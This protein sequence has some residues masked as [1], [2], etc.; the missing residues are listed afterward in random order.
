MPRIYVACLAS[1]NNGTLHGQ[2]ID[3]TA[4]ADEMQ[5]SVSTMLRASP[6]PNVRVPKDD[7]AAERVEELDEE[8]RAY[9]GPRTSDSFAELLIEYLSLTVLSAEEFAIHD[10]DGEELEGLGEY[11]GLAAVAS[12]IEAAELAVDRLG[13][14]G[15]AIVAAFYD[16]HSCRPDDARE[17]VDAVVEAYQGTYDSWTDW[18]EEYVDSTGMLEAMP[19]QLRYY[20]DYEAYGRDVR[21]NGDLFESKGFYFYNR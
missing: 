11:C 5:A 17:A 2:W 13:S 16:Y 7:E 4:D 9:L 20:F 19:E 21:L 3:A 15:V 18:A 10:F 8:I 6:Y 1:Y 12:R 14:D